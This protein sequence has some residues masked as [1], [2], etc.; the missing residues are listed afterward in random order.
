MGCPRPPKCGG[1]KCKANL[2]RPICGEAQPAYRILDMDDVELLWL[3]RAYHGADELR[4]RN[5][6]R[7]SVETTARR[8]VRGGPNVVGS[9]DL[10][11]G[12]KASDRPV[13]AQPSSEP[14]AEPSDGLPQAVASF[15]KKFAPEPCADSAAASVAAPTPPL[16][17]RQFP[18][19]TLCVRV[20]E[21]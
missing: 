16:F 10:C 9:A 12:E 5:A 20:P 2:W 17:V 19:C 14:Q 13:V 7:A 15:G 18:L 1:S 8:S 11:P 6:G 3:L 4:D 21:L